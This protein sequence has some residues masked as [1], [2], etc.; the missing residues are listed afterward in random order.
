[1]KDHRTHKWM[2]LLACILLGAALTGCTVSGQSTANGASIDF[3]APQTKVELA[4][5]LQ[6]LLLLTALTLIPLLLILMTG[7][8]RIV[9]VLSVTRSAIGVPQL[10]PN[11]VIT[12]LAIIL[13]F[14]V[15]S[16]IFVE[17]N[18][19]ALQ[20]YLKGEIEQEQA[21]ERGMAP[22]RTFMFKQVRE[23]DLALFLN[24][25]KLPRPNDQSDVP[26]RVLVPAFVISE[27]RTAFQMAFAIYVPFLV[28]DMVVSS[29]LLSM[30]M[31]MLPPTVISLPFKL[32][33]FV[34]VDGWRLIAQS[35]VLS[36]K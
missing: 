14:F 7:F 17:I 8:V 10:P 15:M 22:L 34:L 12:G 26:A 9:I 11:Q 1:V 2:L 3:G 30:G 36:F 20:P 6:I 28:I 31:M 32:L 21:L 24:L 4:N 18:D 5:S 27:L 13:T 33:L 23:A 25:A 16:P 19:R 35:L 29:G